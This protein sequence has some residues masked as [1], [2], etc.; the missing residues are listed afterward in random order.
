[1]HIQATQW[2]LDALPK[3]EQKL[4][5]KRRNAHETERNEI[6]EEIEK[7][8]L[9]A[10]R[11]KSAVGVPKDEEKGKEKEKG[12]KGLGKKGKEGEGHANKPDKEVN[13]AVVE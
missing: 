2:F 8:V 13:S 1:M 12:V 6:H 3:G 4:S 10:A 11:E 7:E 5:K 9:W